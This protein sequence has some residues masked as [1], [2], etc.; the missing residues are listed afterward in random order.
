MLV[1][2]YYEQGNYQG[3]PPTLEDF[4]DILLRQH[5][6]DA[7][8][9]ALALELFTKG[10]LNT[11]SKQTNVEVNNR[12]ICYDIIDLGEQLTQIRNACY[13]R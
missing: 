3:T 11:F 13:I 6:K 1:Y 5:E 9:I 2:K 12:L 8:D 4:R 10:S 7:K